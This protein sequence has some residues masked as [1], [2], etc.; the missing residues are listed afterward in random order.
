M[1]LVFLEEYPFLRFWLLVGRFSIDF[2]I[3]EALVAPIGRR[4]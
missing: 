1:N 2:L 3:T 4:F